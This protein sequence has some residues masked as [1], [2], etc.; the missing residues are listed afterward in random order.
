MTAFPLH[1]SDAGRA[2]AGFIP[3]KS[4]RDCVTR[5]LAHGLGLPYPEVHQ[6]V[7][8]L[9]REYGTTAEDGA[10]FVVISRILSG[11]GWQHYDASPNARLTLDD[12]R[13]PLSKHS[14]LV[15][16]VSFDPAFDQRGDLWGLD[17]VTSVIDGVVHDIET[18]GAGGF[19]HAP[20]LRNVYGRPADE[21]SAFPSRAAS[22]AVTSSYSPAYFASV[23]FASAR[24]SPSSAKFF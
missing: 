6:I 10:H 5:S 14:V 4:D 18:M 13:L 23:A 9:A 24:A 21:V 22:S 15:V 7:D 17:H 2:E 11:R 12:L 16:E 19:A 20:K 3:A 8:T 1:L